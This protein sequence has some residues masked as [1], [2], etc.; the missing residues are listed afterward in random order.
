MSHR[1][2]K[3]TMFCLFLLAFPA[4]DHFFLTG[5]MK[6]WWLQTGLGTLTFLRLFTSY[7]PKKVLVEEWPNPPLKRKQ[8]HE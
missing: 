2:F 5:R 1:L 3:E 4:V 8:S 7:E 6:I